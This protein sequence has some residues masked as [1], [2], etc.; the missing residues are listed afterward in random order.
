MRGRDF[1]LSL[2]S[3]AQSVTRHAAACDSFPSGSLMIG[4]RWFECRADP[5]ALTWTQAVEFPH[6]RPHFVSAAQYYD[7]RSRR[8]CP[9]PLRESRNAYEQSVSL[10]PSP[11]GEPHIKR[12]HPVGERHLCAKTRGNLCLR[13]EDTIALERFNYLAVGLAP[14]LPSSSHFGERR[15]GPKAEGQASCWGAPSLASEQHRRR[16]VSA[17]GSLTASC[18]HRA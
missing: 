17:R 8:Y 3:A 5:K 6:S 15:G 9:A 12:V 2:T 4:S 18:R 7:F 14:I 10:A 1:V 11:T 16:N 13:I